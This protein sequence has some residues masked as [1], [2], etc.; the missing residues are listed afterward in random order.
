M[1]LCFLVSV[2]VVG[3][4]LVADSEVSVPPDPIVV[5]PDGA[6]V[7]PECFNLPMVS[8]DGQRGAYWAPEKSITCRF[9]EAVDLSPYRT[10][11]LHLHS[12][13]ANNAFLNFVIYSENPETDGTDYYRYDFY[14]DWEGERALTFDLASPNRVGRS[15]LGWHH[16]D[17]I[18][19]WSDYGGIVADKEIIVWSIEFHNSEH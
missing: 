4:S 9:V 12:A 7:S 1:G 6:K 10:V 16:I 13:V 2:L 17:S 18:A 5:T 11:T 15:P 19:F 14:V 3:C 8:K